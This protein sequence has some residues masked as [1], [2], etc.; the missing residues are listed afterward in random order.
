MTNK[1]KSFGIK[2]PKPK[3]DANSIRVGTSAA[4]LK[5][6]DVIKKEVSAILWEIEK[7]HQT[8]LPLD[9]NNV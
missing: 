7:E 2:N 1:Q 3:Y 4:V 6:I 8:H 5:R 9:N